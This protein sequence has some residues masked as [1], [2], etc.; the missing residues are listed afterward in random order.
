[1]IQPLTQRL[2]GVR[3]LGVIN[4]PARLWINLSAHRY[5]TSE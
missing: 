5:F 3:Y 4:K 2:E 1:M